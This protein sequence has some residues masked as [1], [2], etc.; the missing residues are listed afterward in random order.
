MEY[1][2]P[3]S[4]DQVDA[5]LER[6]SDCLCGSHRFVGHDDEL[7]CMVC[8]AYYVQCMCRYAAKHQKIDVNVE[9][10]DPAIQQ[11]IINLMEG[12]S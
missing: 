12:K 5:L 7:Y 3:F 8:D 10:Q 4:Q 2:S 6:G 9:A 1:F 11:G